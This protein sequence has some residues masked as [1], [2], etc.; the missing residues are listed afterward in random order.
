V[1]SLIAL[2]VLNRV[3]RADWR[4]SLAMPSAKVRST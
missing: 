3:R 2:G 1:D 4:V